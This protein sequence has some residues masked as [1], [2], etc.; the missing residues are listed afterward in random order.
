MT[1]KSIDLIWIVVKDLKKS[2]AFYAQKLGMKV[3]SIEEKFGW[4]ELSGQEGGAL[5]GLAQS[6]SEQSL[7]IGSNAIM[8]LTVINIEEAKTDFQKKGVSTI[9]DILEVPG[10][11]KLQMMRDDDGNHF[12]LVQTLERPF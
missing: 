3:L 4:A 2:V 6:N 1:I 9:G 11:V 12:Q 10:V 5:L 8:A 7:P